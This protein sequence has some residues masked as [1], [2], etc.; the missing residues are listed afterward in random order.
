[1]YERVMTLREKPLV[2]ATIHG[3][4]EIHRVQGGHNAE[5]GRPDRKLRIVLPTGLSVVVGMECAMARNAWIED[6]GGQ[7]TPKHEHFDASSDNAGGV[8]LTPK[9]DQ[10]TPQEVRPAIR[11][12]RRAVQPS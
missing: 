9:K 3:P 6:S 4:I 1:M 12:V 11:V 8:S 10:R 2:I 5:T 7:I